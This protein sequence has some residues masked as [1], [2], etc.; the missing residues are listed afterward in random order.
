[1]TLTLAESAA[2]TALAKHEIDFQPGSGKSSTAFP[3]AAE[4]AGIPQAWPALKLS[5]LPSITQMLTWTLEQR[6]L[7]EIPVP[8]TGIFSR[9]RAARRLQRHLLRVASSVF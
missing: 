7:L 5:E 3:I 2:V 8:G 1:M 9:H 4:R 6:L